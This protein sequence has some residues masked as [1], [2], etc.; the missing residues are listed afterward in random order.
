[1]ERWAKAQ[2]KKKDEYKRLMEGKNLSGLT[3][4]SA[5]GITSFL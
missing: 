1:M 3:K 5:T 4:E 2:N